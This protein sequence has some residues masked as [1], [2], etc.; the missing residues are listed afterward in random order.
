ML[1]QNKFI[2]N[3][4]V[5]QMVRFNKNQILY[6]RKLA[7]NPWANCRCCLSYLL[8]CLQQAG[9]ILLKITV[10]AQEIHFC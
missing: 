10:Y 4:C 3:D 7:K 1:R 5:F 8:F 9:N 2:A 6:V